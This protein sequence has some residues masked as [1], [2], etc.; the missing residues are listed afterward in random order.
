MGLRSVPLQVV[1]RILGHSSITMT[2]KYA[3]ST[4]DAER[5]AVEV[6]GFI[7]RKVADRPSAKSAKEAVSP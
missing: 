4:D 3:H 5:K 2:E 7:G 1:Q 6:L